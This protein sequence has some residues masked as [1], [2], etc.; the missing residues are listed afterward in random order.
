MA[1][2]GD[3][4]LTRPI[5]PSLALTEDEPDDCDGLAV[6]RYSWCGVRS[7]NRMGWSVGIRG[8]FS[9]HRRF[10]DRQSAN[11]LPCNRRFYA[12]IKLR[13]HGLVRS[14]LGTYIIHA[15]RPAGDNKKPPCT[16]RVLSPPRVFLSCFLSFSR[17]FWRKLALL[18][19]TG[20]RVFSSCHG[21]TDRR[22]P[23]RARCFPT[24]TKAARC[25]RSRTRRS[26]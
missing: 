13:P 7:S 24:A 19:R 11:G 2:R 18:R 25:L 23:T 17:L 22:I 10:D 26:P 14:H 16:V 5:P 12:L 1:R 6:N 21:P 20:K 9:T 8:G 4:G 15:D 3:P